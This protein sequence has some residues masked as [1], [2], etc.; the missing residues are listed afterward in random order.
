MNG[1]VLLRISILVSLLTVTF[2]TGSEAQVTGNFGVGVVKPTE[3]Q[4]DAMLDLYLDLAGPADR[5]VTWR[6]G[7]GYQYGTTGDSIGSTVTYNGSTVRGSIMVSPGAG[8]KRGFY[9]GAGPSAIYRRV[10]TEIWGTGGGRGVTYNCAG[11]SGVNALWC[12]MSNNLSSYGTSDTNYTDTA[13]KFGGHVFS[14]FARAP[15]H[16][17]VLYERGPADDTVGLGGLTFRFGL[18]W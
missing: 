1:R 9:F 10:S 2:A 6:V 7:G 17:E 13:W 4:I 5:H 8:K 11:A 3:Q 14:G 18:S 12:N 15:W 16:V